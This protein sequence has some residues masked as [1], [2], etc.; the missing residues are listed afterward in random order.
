M[1][2]WCFMKN[3]LNDLK[4][5]LSDFTYPKIK[6]LGVV[7]KVLFTKSA[8]LLENKSI[9]LYFA[10]KP[11]SWSKIIFSRTVI[12]NN[13]NP[14]EAEKTAKKSSTRLGRERTTTSGRVRI[15]GCD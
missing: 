14:I 13:F 3:S 6:P 2:S 10:V 8:G 12:C 1:K 4:R 11:I 15:I 7:T 9:L 5:N